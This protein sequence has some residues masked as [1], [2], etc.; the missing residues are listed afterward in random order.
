MKFLLAIILIG[1]L[2]LFN[3][4]REDQ[5]VINLQKQEWQKKV[6][7]E[8]K[9]KDLAIDNCKNE[10]IRKSRDSKTVSF[11]LLPISSRTS[12]GFRVS[13]LADDR[14][15]SYQIVCYTGVSGSNADIDIKP[16]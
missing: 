9:N 3:W 13:F 4:Y 16:R 7:E 10:F 8:N 1:G 2:Y 6:D 15:G 5:K 11:L 12:G 14:Y